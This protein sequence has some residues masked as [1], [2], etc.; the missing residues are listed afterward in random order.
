[1]RLGEAGGVAAGLLVQQ[2]VHVALAVEGDR[3][4]AVPGDG[5]EPHLLEQGVQR[6]RLR[7]RVLDEFEAVGAGGVL[8]RDLRGRRVV[9]K[10]TH[11][12]SSLVWHDPWLLV[13]RT[14]HP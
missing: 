8:R 4:R 7:M 11:L 14:G 5:R 3:P 1:V 6:L 9:R 2:V 12:N 13:G 10:R